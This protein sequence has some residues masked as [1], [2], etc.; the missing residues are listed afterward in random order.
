[1][2]KAD[3]V[4]AIGIERMI[5]VR[6]MAETIKMAETKDEI[7]YI[8]QKMQDELDKGFAEI[9]KIIDEKEAG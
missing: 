1:M 7:Q 3:S 9:D 5:I 4:L 2:N 6:G 8:L